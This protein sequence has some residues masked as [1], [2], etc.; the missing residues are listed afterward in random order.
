MKPN[1]A[2]TKHTTY[3][4]IRFATN[5][6]KI[7]WDLWNK[8]QT[9]LSLC[10]WNGI[11]LI[12]MLPLITAAAP[13][14]CMGQIASWSLKFKIFH[15]AKGIFQF[16]L[17]DLSEISHLFHG[18][19][20]AQSNHQSRWVTT[21][22]KTFYALSNILHLVLKWKGVI[23]AQDSE[24]ARTATPELFHIFYKLL[25]GRHELPIKPIETVFN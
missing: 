14:W 16:V 17:Q 12:I 22:N 18:I 24:N 3:L 10:L 25:C 21:G 19:R 6:W 15:V 9:I 2:W 1:A 7:L 20:D 23:P 8:I 4:A 11:I 13:Y 5:L